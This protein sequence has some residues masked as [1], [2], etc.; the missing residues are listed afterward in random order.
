MFHEFFE[1][2]RFKLILWKFHR[3]KK[4]VKRIMDNKRKQNEYQ[5]WIKFNNHDHKEGCE[6]CGEVYEKKRYSKFL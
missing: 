4:I 1:K 3:M 6:I 2:I 5:A